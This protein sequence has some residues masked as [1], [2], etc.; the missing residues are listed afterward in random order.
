ME[1]LQ[2]NYTRMLE[3]LTLKYQNLVRNIKL[4][5]FE[6]MM[7]VQPTPVLDFPRLLLN[8][9]NRNIGS[10]ISKINDTLLHHLAAFRIDTQP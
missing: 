9:Y 10:T 4:Y 5:W 7:E 6:Q 1:E 2:R 3:H 8:K